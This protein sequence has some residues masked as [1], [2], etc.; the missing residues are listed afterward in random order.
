MSPDGWL[1]TGDLGCLDRAGRLWLLGRAKDMIKTGGENVFAPEVEAAL[2]SHP[3]VEQAA[4]VGLP[5]ERLGEK[6]AALVVIPA[7]SSSWTG[8][9]TGGKQ[10]ERTYALLSDSDNHWEGN[11]RGSTADDSGTSTSDLSATALQ[12]WCR[13]QGLAGFKLPRLIAAQRHPLPVNASG[14]VV[15]HQVRRDLQD[16]LQNEQQ[17]QIKSKL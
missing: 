14:K 9:L 17:Q 4:V 5:D 8:L 12:D 6:V 2:C 16:L 13:R 10:F 3:K 15:K 7:A 11:H 1:R